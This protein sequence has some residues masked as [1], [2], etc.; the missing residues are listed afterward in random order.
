LLI[1]GGGMAVAAA[2]V[3]TRPKATPVT[4]SEKA[5][6]VSATPASPG[7]FAPMVPLYGRV[8]SLWSSALTA[9]I[10]ADVVEVPVIEGDEVEEGD[11]LVR[12]D[13][14][15]ARLVLDQRAAELEEAEARIAAEQIAHQ[16][17]TDALP[18]ERML[19]Q[20]A[21]AE[22]RRTQDLV[23]KKAGSQSTLDTARQAVERQAIS[24]RAR[25]QLVAGH[26]ASLAELEARRARAEAL[27]DQARLELART[28]VTAPFPGRIARVLVSPGKRVRVGDAVIELYDTTAL[29]VRALLPSRYLPE[30]RGAIRSGETLRAAGRL[31]GLAVTAGL[32]RLAGA[33]AGGSG[34]LEGLFR[35]EQGAEFLQEGRFVNLD[36]AL[37]VQEGIVALPHEAIYG[38]DRIYVVD[39]ESRL[40]AV[41]VSRV[42]ETR[43]GDAGSRVLVRSP[44]LQPGD[45]V[46]TTQLPNA[47]DGLLVRLAGEK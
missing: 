26:A 21:E 35:I 32:L 23:R 12:L 10:A 24:L 34:G 38:T 31:E 37:P 39:G 30:I 28:R 22:L 45:L 33:V 40:R 46:M 14:R 4:V 16:A 41:R 5:W 47:I 9:G 18:R 43:E 36:L 13:E 29:V 44:D 11:L 20:L 42:G 27:R 8:E 7:A 6:L 3:A 2:F 1:L 19:L 15:D 17:N 25:E